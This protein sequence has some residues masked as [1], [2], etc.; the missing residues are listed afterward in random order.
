MTGHDLPVIWS[1]KELA[2][3][4]SRDHPLFV[5]YS[6]G[7]RQDEDQRS[8]DAESGLPLPG[9]SVNPL[10]PEPWWTRPLMDWLARQL[11]QYAHLAAEDQ[12]QPWILTGR[13]VGRGPDC[14]PLVDDVTA[15]AL[16]H[17]D[18]IAE[19]EQHYG[20]RFDKGARPT[21]S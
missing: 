2:D 1:L 17:C 7:P 3:L 4:V 20:A 19:A 16:L 21:D 8:L 14:E 10:N 13:C 18:L 11:C 12:R 5:R 6:Q 15:I 9:L